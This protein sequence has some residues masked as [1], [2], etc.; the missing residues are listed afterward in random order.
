MIHSI[1]KHDLLDIVIISSL[2]F[3][4]CKWQCQIR[5]TNELA[6]FAIYPVDFESRTLIWYFD[7]FIGWQR[8]VHRKLVQP[9]QVYAACIHENIEKY[10]NVLNAG[11]CMLCLVAN[12]ME[13]KDE[14]SIDFF[15]LLSIFFLISKIYLILGNPMEFYCLFKL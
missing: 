7:F 14:K 3:S 13:G 8:E 12:F 6:Q 4:F 9:Q 5:T 15:K 11:L 1:F 10:S 2:M